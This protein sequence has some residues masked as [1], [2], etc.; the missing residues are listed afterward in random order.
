METSKVDKLF[1]NKRIATTTIT[2]KNKVNILATSSKQRVVDK[3]IKVTRDMEVHIS[4]KVFQIN[5][6]KVIII[7]R[8]AITSNGEEATK[9]ITRPITKD[10]TITAG[11][12]ILDKVLEER[13]TQ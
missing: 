8:R 13:I 12:S 5:F 10:S 11:I 6:T 4:N 7:Q 1:I 9:T 3:V 2:G